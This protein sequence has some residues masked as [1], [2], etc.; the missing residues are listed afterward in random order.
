MKITQISIAIIVF[1][2]VVSCKDKEQQNQES[3]QQTAQPALTI[4]IQDEP[5]L[6][7]NMIDAIDRY[8]SDM[9]VS[10]NKPS[11]GTHM[12]T[13]W[14]R[15][16]MKWDDV[17]N[18]QFSS[19]ELMN[20]DKSIGKTTCATIHVRSWPRVL[21]SQV[22][23]RLRKFSTILADT[24]ENGEKYPFIAV[25]IGEPKSRDKVK[26]FCGVYTQ[27]Y[28]FGPKE[29]LETGPIV[30]GMFEDAQ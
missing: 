19:S 14:A 3:S 29:N 16:N 13:L 11:R 28:T 22:N 23:G 21:Y 8:R 9:A 30:V 2:C 4:S 27:I 26:K 10:E 1:T 7:A 15:A 6:P 17:K 24:S 12:F 18:K 20:N 5:E 25:A